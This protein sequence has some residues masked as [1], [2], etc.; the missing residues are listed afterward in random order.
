LRTYTPKPADIQ[1]E[2][3]VIDATDVRLGHLAVQVANLLRGKH[4]TMF[5]SHVDTGDF[6]IVINAAK[7]SL[8]G[9]KATK[10][11]S[12]R[13][14]GYP[15]GLSATPMGDLLQKDSRK[16]VERA[17]WGMLPKNR[18]GRQVIKK[19]K[20]Y[21]GPEHPH[22]AQKAAPFEIKQISQ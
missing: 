19:L 18:L 20:V 14:S 15:G 21:A 9:D 1:R 5:A 2:W 7:L 3:H 16:A 10:K 13:H 11:L 22:A 8:S 4:K 6:V 17:V 12:Y